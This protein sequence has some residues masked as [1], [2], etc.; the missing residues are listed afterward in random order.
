MSQRAVEQALGRLLTD[1]EFR[2]RFFADP[3]RTSL[4]A[5]LD[6]SPEELDALM[7]VPRHALAA[8]SQRIDDRICRLCVPPAPGA[9][10]R[11]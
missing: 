10:E 4:V 7:R 8:L 9:E 11:F 6:L 5:G 1:E 2:R 3:C